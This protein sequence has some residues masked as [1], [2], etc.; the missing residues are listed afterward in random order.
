MIMSGDESRIAEMITTLGID[1][2]NLLQ[3]ALEVSYFSRGAW[4]YETVLEMTPLERDLAV[5]FVN[6]RLEAASKATFPVY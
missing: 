1:T 5:A 4:P 2:R 3:T 6:K